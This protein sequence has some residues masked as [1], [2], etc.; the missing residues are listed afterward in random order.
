MSCVKSNSLMMRSLLLKVGRRLSSGVLLFLLAFCLAANK[1]RAK[2]EEKLASKR[3][4]HALTWQSSGSDHKRNGMEPNRA[5]LAHKLNW[6]HSMS[7]SMSSRVSGE[8]GVW[9]AYRQH[10]NSFNN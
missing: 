8:L 9:F 3:G 1:G 2:R 5:L 7:V 6:T 4:G 10:G